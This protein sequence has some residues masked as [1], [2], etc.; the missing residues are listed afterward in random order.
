MA[1]R[2]ES[3]FPRDRLITDPAELRVYECD[4]LPVHRQ[5]PRLVALCDSRD[6][7]VQVVR[8]CAGQSVPFI[9]RGAGTGLS[10]GATP[11]P[12]AVLIDVNRM[13]K[14]KSIDLANRIAVV[15]PGVINLHLSQ[16]VEK[17]GYVYAPDP[18]SQSACTLGGNI[19]ENSGGPHC[20]KYGVTS[21]HVL[22]LEVVLPDGE[23]AQL[24]GP[25]AEPGG[26]DLVSLFTGSEGTFG[27][28]T[29]ITCRLTPKPEAVR[30][31][32]AIYDS[33]AAACRTVSEITREGILPVAL[34]ILDQ[35]TIRA[36]EASVYAAGYP[37]NAAA[38]LLIELDGFEAGMD[39]DEE[40]ITRIVRANSPL[41]MRSAR[42]PQQRTMLW[43]GRKGAFGAM[44]RV[45]TDL[46]VLDGC[47][48]RTRLE[49]T[50]SQVYEIADRH[51]VVVSNV[52]HAGDGNLHPN[53]SYDGRDAELTARVLA[54]G[55][56]MLRACVDAGGTIS[57]EHGIGI[58][59]REFMPMIYD[60]NDL[61]LQVAIR[62]AIDPGQLANP[63]KI[64][65]ERSAWVRPQDTTNGS[66]Q[67]SPHARPPSAHEREFRIAEAE[68]PCP[69]SLDELGHRIREAEAAG[70]RV[71]PAGLGAHAYAPVPT[72]DDGPF[73]VLSTQM[74]DGIAEYEPGDYT[75]GVRAGTKLEDLERILAENGQE[76]PWDGA[77]S[78]GGTVGGL[79]ARAPS[80]PR[81]GRYG[82][83]GTFLL[84]IEGMRAR[85]ERYKAGGMVVK[86]VSGYQIWKL[87]AGSWGSLGFLLRAKLQ[88]SPHSGKTFGSRGRVPRSW[89]SPRV[90][91]RGAEHRLEPAAL[92][93]VETSGGGP[94]ATWVWEGNAPA[95][96]WQDQRA[97]DLLAGRDANLMDGVEDPQARALLRRLAGIGFPGETPAPDLGIAQLSVLP[98]R[99]SAISQDVMEAL[100][101]ELDRGVEI[102]RACDAMT[103][104]LDGALAC[105]GKRGC[106]CGCDRDANLLL[107]RARTGS[108]SSCGRLDR[109]SPAEGAAPHLRFASL[110][111]RTRTFAAH[112]SRIPRMT[113]TLGES[114]FTAKFAEYTRTLDCVHCGLCIPHC[115]THGITGREADSPRGRIYLMRAWAESTLDLTDEAQL[116]LDQCIVCRA[117]ES[118]CPSGIRMGEMMESFR[119]ERSAERPARGFGAGL[120]RF[121]CAVSSPTAGALRFCPMFWR[122]TREAAPPRSL[123]RS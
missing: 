66:G 78:E 92:F 34:E 109:L 23:V 72:T 13:R 16:A 36:V 62:D 47:V 3:I 54:A 28:V 114:A 91:C 25:I 64:F 101:G 102:V 29:E 106:R 88:A 115:P 113:K 21:D 4:G 77:G 85:G 39:Q 24:G 89:A 94:M 96:E 19:A 93:V 40:A 74:L 120:S 20:L 103:G 122:S 67:G 97:R 5:V 70:R 55:E 38:V 31:F 117:C 17:G 100:A 48:P 22:A 65:P 35:R 53:I 46:Y 83:M 111:S 108:I 52:F 82:S 9:A 1:Q 63:G 8:W 30:T 43:K 57:G 80:G 105:P 12:G 73:Q 42:D 116:H 69:R 81:R 98:S 56:E 61:G 37:A 18:S 68:I 95:V 84:G 27:V 7:V 104:I 60:A 6:E 58:E 41:E 99:L 50:L 32:L 76:I 33:M 112:S 11:V 10:G 51:R 71:I 119:H 75:I 59:K 118:V 14:I 90:C 26:L 45:D 44:G 86:N 87:H 49:S 15:E 110:R 2:L 79:V 107:A 123:V 121:S